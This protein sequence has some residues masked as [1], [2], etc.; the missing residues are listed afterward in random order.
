MLTGFLRAAVPGVGTG[1][2]QG[3]WGLTPWQEGAVGLPG[4]ISVAAQLLS[5][6]VGR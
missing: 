5:L 1:S 3:P 6:H 4:E 2:F